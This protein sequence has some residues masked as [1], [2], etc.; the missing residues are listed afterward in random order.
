[1]WDPGAAR[2]S[3][4]SLAIATDRL[5]SSRSVRNPVNSREDL[6]GAFNSITYQKGGAVLEMLETWLGKD[7][8]RQ[9]VRDYLQ[10]HAWGSATSSDFFGAV[11]A[12]SG[13]GPEALKAFEGFVDQSGLPLIDLELACGKEGPAIQVSQQRLKPKGSTAVD[14]EWTTPACFRREG[15]VQCDTIT[16]PPRSIAL[17]GRTCPGYVLGNAGGSG[18]YVVRYGPFAWKRILAPAAKWPAPEAAALLGDTTILAQS[19]LVP[20]ES[21]LALAD[22]AL[23]HRSAAVQLGAVR[24]LEKIPDAWL[25]DAQLR[26]KR[27]VIVTRLQPLAKRVGWVEKPKEPYEVMDLRVELMP[28]AARSEGG[29]PLR[30]QARRLG[31]QWLRVPASLPSTMVPPVLDTTARF[32]DR[33]SYELLESL[34]ATT[35]DGFDRRRLQAALAKTRDPALRTRALGLALRKSGGSDVMNGREAS[36]FL[37]DAMGDEANRTAAFDYVRTNFDAIA[38]KVAPSAPGRFP[39]ALHGICRPAEREA[40]VAFFKDRAPRYE[41]GR[42]SYDEA[43]EAIDLCIAARA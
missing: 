2:A 11:G 32:A 14:R 41:A 28:L 19:G 34:A 42:R 25:T 27:A 7:E 3:N 33:A 12:A 29:A 31:V 1:V 24:L 38:A 30:A 4:P 37:R 21:A 35:K 20:I 5:V 9:G 13:R 16:N 8:F 36:L 26:K 40:F 23:A 18:Y 17:A 10:K 39:Q 43:L 15:D 22:A 6:E